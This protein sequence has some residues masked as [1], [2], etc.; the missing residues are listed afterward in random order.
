MTAPT[1]TANRVLEIAAARGWEMT[2]DPAQNALIAS[3]EGVTTVIPTDFGEYFTVLTVASDLEIDPVRMDDIVEHALAKH[4]DTYFGT[5][6]V[7]QM[8]NDTLRVGCSVSMPAGAGATDEQLDHWLEV[9]VACA[10]EGLRGT[11]NSLNLSNYR[12]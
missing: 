12:V 7:H 8:P 10:A 2:E 4:G 3:M 11:V 9:C 6:G 1:I 5:I